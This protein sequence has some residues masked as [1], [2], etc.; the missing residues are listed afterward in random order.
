MAKKE[1]QTITIGRYHFE[2][3]NDNKILFPKSKI[4]KGDLIDYYY[5]IAPLLLKYSK[6]H[7]ISMIRYPEGI[8][9]EGFYQ[10]DAPDYF[11]DWI[12]TKTIETKEH[13]K[14]RYVVLDKV[15]TVVYLAS[16]ACI[17][18]H[19]WLSKLNSLHK[20]D[21]MI[22]DL[23]PSDND[24]KKVQFA[25][26]KIKKLLDELQITSFVTTTGSR[27]MHIVVPLQPKYS[28]EDV[29]DCA[30]KIAQFLSNAYPK[31]L[32]TELRIEKRDNKVFLDYLRNAYSATAVAAYAVRPKE[33]APVATPISWQ[34]AFDKRLK[35]TKYT[36]KNIFKKLE[37]DGDPWQ[38]MMQ[39]KLSLTSLKKQLA[40]LG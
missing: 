21:R 12:T 39:H 24:F 2:A 7:L 22:F 8:L 16:Q 6:N 1:I 10:K 15:A 14:V 28:F 11:P 4:T 19:I 38:G 34:E 33:H 9:G 27:G 40:D 31:K 23:D 3:S 17:T 26:D 29:R 25:A 30:Q 35:S 36:I 18:P 20:P 32:T 37:D 13:K 5:S